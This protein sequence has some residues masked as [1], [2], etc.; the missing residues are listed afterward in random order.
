MKILITREMALGDVILTTPIIRQL[1]QNY[2]GD[3]EIS[4]STNNPEVFKNNPYIK[5]ILNMNIDSK[6]YDFHI[7]LNLAYEMQP[8]KHIITA[9]SEEAKLELLINKQPEL[10]PDENDVLYVNNWINSNLNKK[11]LAI[12]MRKTFGSARNFSPEFW[13]KIING[14][15]QNSDL[16]ILQIGGDS[17]I[18]FQEQPRL[19]VSRNGSIHKVQQFIKHA[20]VFLGVDSGLLHIAATT[21][22]PIVSI[23]TIAHHE[24]RKPLRENNL[25]FPMFPETLNCYGCVKDLPIPATTHPC[26]RND[27]ACLQDISTDKIIEN[28]LKFSN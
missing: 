22:T 23:F 24:Y 3:C 28:I 5:H 16:D 7:N 21:N 19:K 27:L 18:L 11:F 4:V 8:I 10:F 15:L 20:N 13:Q 26:R 1:Y 17:D 6:N 25:F 14:V 12:H 9:Y 2:N